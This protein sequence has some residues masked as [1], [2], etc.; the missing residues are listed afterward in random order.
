[1]SLEGRGV[2]SGMDGGRVPLGHT[3]L[4]APT[5]YGSHQAKPGQAE[6]ALGRAGI[7]AANG[8]S[9]LGMRC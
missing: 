7:S 9:E 5:R 8:N 1:M 6:I 2:W 4:S 3:G